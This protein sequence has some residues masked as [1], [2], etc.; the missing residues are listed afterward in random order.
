MRMREPE[1][2][3]AFYA[4]TVSSVTSQMHALAGGD[5]QADH[6]IRE[7]YARAYQ[8][9][10]EVSGYR[11][12]EGWVL[13]VAREAFDRRRSQE[14]ST[15]PARDSGTWPGMYRPRAGAGSGT[16]DPES[17]M[18]SRGNAPSGPESPYQ[19]AEPSPAQPAGQPTAALAD[20]VAGAAGAGAAWPATAGADAAWPATADAAWPPTPGSGMRGSAAPAGTAPGWRS[21]PGQPGGNRQLIAIV[22]VVALLVVGGIAYVA[23]GRTSNGSPSADT[24]PTAPVARNAGPRMLPAGHTGSL[25]A[26]PW[27]I[28]GSGW[29]LAD[30]STGQPHP[31]GQPTGGA[32]TTF[33]VDPEGGKYRIYQW[34]AGSSPELLAWSG[35]TDS[36]LFGGSGGY[37]LLT[38][39]GLP[40]SGQV[41]P[42]TLPAGVSP[43]GFTRP[44]GTNILAVRQGPV[45]NKLQRY[46]LSGQFQAT[47]ATMPRR[48]VQGTLPGTCASSVC[49]ALSSPTGIMAVWGLRG[50]EMQLVSNVGG[51]IRRLHVPGSGL[52]PS[53]TP[54][55]WWNQTTILANCSAPGPLGLQLRLWLVPDDGTT[56][57][58][59]TAASG[60]PSGAGFFTSAWQAAGHVFATTTSSA[61]CSGAPS[62]P[63][64]LAIMNVS[65]AGSPTQVTVPGST[66]NYSTVVGGSGGRLVVLA[67]TGCPGSSSLLWLNPLSGV[68]QPL[69]Q[70][71]TG[72]AG[73]TAAVPWGLGPTATAG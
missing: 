20:G 59:L 51:L 6:A 65:Q 36:A 33:L 3:D 1:T 18:T 63:G 25:A 67:Q 66:N 62:G 39:H 22:A 38:L 37:Q 32:T 14:P 12:P 45:L 28:V 15:P 9:W 70:A 8:Q 68:A 2:F 42:L 64:G 48:P 35:S 47:L 13:D 26:V 55:S 44:D 29:T 52:P 34:P 30:F 72:E 41:V 43:A 60:N 10:Y 24:G 23:F 61:E 58:P 71:P 11:N 17:T 46:N 56:P 40:G 16:P 5:P 50:D 27:S 31:A 69:L 7:A 21:R 4:R 19:S 57:T 53:C 73:V 49:G 54:V